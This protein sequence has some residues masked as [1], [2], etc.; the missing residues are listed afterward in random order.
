MRR[1]YRILSWL[2]PLCA[3]VSAVGAPAE[4]LLDRGYRQMYNLEFEQAHRTFAERQRQH[5]GD[6]LAPASDAACYLFA[7]FD[8]LHILQA[9]FFLHDENFRTTRRL[10]PNPTVQAAFQSQLAKSEELAAKVLAGAPNDSNALFAKVLVLGL[11]S[12]YEALIEKRYF[13]S[14]SSTKNSRLTAEKLLAIDPECYDAWLAI[15]VE[16]Y[17]LSLKPL[18]VRWFLQLGGNATDRELGLQKLRITAAKGRYLR[19]FAR[20]LLAVAALRDKDIARVK[21]IL[22]ELSAEFPGNRLYVEELARLP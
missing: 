8:R 22:Q 20:L 17:L 18:P 4:D 11:R 9:E 14:L 3:A 12:D 19:P 21:S 13:S 10:A 7:E 15:G 2:M 5:P 6:P 1:P 16:N